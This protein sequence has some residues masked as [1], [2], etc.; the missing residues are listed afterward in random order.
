MSAIARTA[1]RPMLA[2][3]ADSTGVT[4]TFDYTIY[5]SVTEIARFGFRPIPPEQLA[6]RDDG[7]P[8][9][10]TAIR[11]QL[12]LKLERSEDLVPVVVIES[13]EQPTEN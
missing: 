10:E 1:S 11:E 6:G 8:S 12:G 3:V 13:I 9:F 2:F 7:L 4:G 5:T